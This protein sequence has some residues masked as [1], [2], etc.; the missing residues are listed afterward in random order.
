MMLMVTNYLGLNGHKAFVANRDKPVGF[1]ECVPYK[2][3]V[4]YNGGGN[5][6]YYIDQMAACFTSSHTT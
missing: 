2:T 3:G 1:L 6:P 4:A 5:D